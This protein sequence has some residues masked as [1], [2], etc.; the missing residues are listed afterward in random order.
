MEKVT[1]FLL[2]C[3]TDQKG[4]PH[5]ICGEFMYVVFPCQG[6]VGGLFHNVMHALEPATAAVQQSVGSLIPHGKI[7]TGPDKVSQA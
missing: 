3:Q 5:L 6:F 7:N 2:Y 1:R 4:A